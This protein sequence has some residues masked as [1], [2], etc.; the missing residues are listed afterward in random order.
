MSGA[1][2][3]VFVGVLVALLLGMVALLLW[4]EG[5]RRSFDTM[6]E[7]VVDQLVTFVESRLD[8]SVA[9]RLGRDAV[10]RIVNWELRYLQRDGGEGAVAGGTEDSVAYIV[11]GI[12]QFHGVSYPHD[13]VR[14]VLAW[15]AEY[16]LAAG[17]FGE[18]VVTEGD[19]EE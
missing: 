10:E 19:G 6:P 13:D 17:A 12:A 14:A 15:E 7:Y 8:P 2:L 9:E 5:R 3:V 1:T 18:P 16:L 4:Q 11:D